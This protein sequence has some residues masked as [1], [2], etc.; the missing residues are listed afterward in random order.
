VYV[1]SQLVYT[2]GAAA[3]ALSRHRIAVVLLTYLGPAVALLSSCCP[4]ARESCT[5]HCSPCPTCSS[6]T[7]TRPT[8]YTNQPLSL[9]RIFTSQSP[10]PV[11]KRGIVMTMSLCL[12]ASVST[13]KNVRSSPNLLCVLHNYGRGSVLFWRRCDMLCTS[14]FVND[15]IFVHNVQNK[16]RKQ[17]LYCD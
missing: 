9:F 10:P 17:S 13:E 2:V 4:S 16:R 14:G 7:T 15:V 6:H 5:R 11:G 3:M 8:R 1:V 12:S